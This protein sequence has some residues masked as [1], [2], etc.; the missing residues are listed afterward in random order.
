MALTATANQ[1]AVQDII[2]GLQIGG[3]QS[4]KMSFNRPN[5]TYTVIRLSNK[6]FDNMLNWINEQHQGHSGII[7]CQSKAK[8]EEFAKAL[9][10]KGLKANYYHADIDPETK[11]RVQKDWQDGEINIIVATVCSICLPYV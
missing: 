11:I 5:L 1:Q 8:C 7:Y 2:R 3:C 6:V 9:N 10:S 4:L